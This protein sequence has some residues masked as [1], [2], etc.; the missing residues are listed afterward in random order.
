MYDIVHTV[1]KMC[2][3]IVF[4]QQ[5]VSGYMPKWILWQYPCFSTILLNLRKPYHK[6]CKLFSFRLYKM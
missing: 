6:L 4:V 3:T 5:Y 2:H 1:Y